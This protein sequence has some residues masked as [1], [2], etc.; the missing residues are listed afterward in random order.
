M[1]N[2]WKWK[3]S[4]CQKFIKKNK[5]YIWIENNTNFPKQINNKLFE[6]VYN[7]YWSVTRVYNP[8]NNFVNKNNIYNEICTTNTLAIP[9]G[10]KINHEYYGLTKVLDPNTMPEKVVTEFIN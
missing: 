9:V 6:I 7:P 1:L 10:I 8:S 5:P 3:C 4:R 2:L